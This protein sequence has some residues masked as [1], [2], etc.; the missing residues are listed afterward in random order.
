LKLT[1]RKETIYEIRETLKKSEI[2]KIV[3]KILE[4]DN[5]AL[6]QIEPTAIKWKTVEA[7]EF[8]VS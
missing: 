3:S 6:I 7:E 2:L 8:E 5:V 1:C 4:K